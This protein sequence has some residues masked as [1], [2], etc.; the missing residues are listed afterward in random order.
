MTEEQESIRLSYHYEHRGYDNRREKIKLVI[1]NLKNSPSNVEGV[2]RVHSVS[3]LKERPS[4]WY[5]DAEKE[6]CILYLD[7]QNRWEGVV[8]K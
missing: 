7:Q 4:A 1:K 3:E 6:E 8:Y 5:Y 2:E